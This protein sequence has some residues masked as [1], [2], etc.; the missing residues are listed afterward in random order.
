VSSFLFTYSLPP[1]WTAKVD[2][3][4]GLQNNLLKKGFQAR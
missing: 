1:K 2:K 3:Y 4:S